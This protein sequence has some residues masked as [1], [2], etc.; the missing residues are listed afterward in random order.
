MILNNLLKEYKKCIFCNYKNLKIQKNQSFFENFYVKSIISDLK[1]SKIFLKKIKV[2][3]CGNCHIIQNNPWF[4][5]SVSRKIY[6][7]IYGQH[8]RAW[9][10]LINYIKKKQKPNHGELFDILNKNLKIRTYA[11]FNSPFMGMFFNFF[12]NE[13]K[14]NS[15]VDFFFKK[16]LHYLTSR[17]MAGLPKNIQKKSNSTSKKALIY[18]NNFK[19]KNIKEKTKKYLFVDN[20][21]LSWGQN[22]NYKSVNSKSFATEFF[23]MEISNIKKIKKKMDLFGI[24]HTLDHTFEPKKIF[25]FAIRNSKCLVVYCHID[26]R[27]NKQHL[28]SITKDFLK[29]LKKKKLY[30]LDITNYLNKKFT[31]PEIYFVCSKQKSYINRIKSYVS[32]KK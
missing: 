24:F 6:S 30:F 17:Q 22:D 29:Y 1:L 8:H 21:I 11:E 18:I 4:N 12:D 32:K 13:I 2:Y 15:R 5:E 19:N 28:F 16:I 3:K 25:D 9:T 10:N 26:E 31:S 27:L 7:N 14:K 20:S 23:N